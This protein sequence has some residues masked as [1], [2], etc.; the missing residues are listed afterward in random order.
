MSTEFNGYIERH[1]GDLLTSEDWN[2]VQRKIRDD[3]KSQ[4]EEAVAKIKK[5]AKADD[6]HTLDNQ[7]SDDLT[8]SILEQARQELPKR[9]GYRRIFKRLKLGQENLVKHNLGGCPLVDIYALYPFDVVCSEDDQKNQEQ[10]YFYLYHSSERRIRYTPPGGAPAPAPGVEIEPTGGTPFRISFADML[11][12][13][14]VRYTDSSSLDDLETE[15]WEAFLKDP[16]DDFDD[17]QYCHS[18]WFD[19]CCGERRTVGELKSRGDWDELWFKMIPRKTINLSQFFQPGIVTAGEGTADAGRDTMA[20]HNLEVVHF[21][22]NT[23]G[24]T[25]LPPR[26]KTE[27]PPQMDIQSVMVLLKV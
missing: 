21:D 17:D 12:Y 6:A 18:P 14:D 9:T 24:I 23:L 20:P 5:V 11:A 22:F 26:Q 3:I 10:V 4:I 7:T 2:S 13:Y 19:R 25:F 1:P 15:F 8:K 27:Y 16:N